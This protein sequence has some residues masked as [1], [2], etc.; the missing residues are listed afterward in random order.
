MKACPLGLCLTEMSSFMRKPTMWFPNRS[1]TNRSV[2]AQKM[3]RGWKLWFKKVEE[4]YYPCGESNGAYQLR[5]YCEA[6]LRLC[7]C[8]CK[9][10]VFLMTRLKLNESHYM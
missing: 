2:Q 1:D 7:F 10:L 6:D 5:S 4:L 3:A 8:L 9:M